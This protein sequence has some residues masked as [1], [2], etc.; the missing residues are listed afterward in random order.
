MSAGISDAEFESLQ[1]QAKSDLERVIPFADAAMQGADSE[2]KDDMWSSEKRKCYML[3]LVLLC[4]FE[5]VCE[6]LRDCSQSI[7]EGA[8]DIAGATSESGTDIGAGVVMAVEQ[9]LKTLA[10]ENTHNG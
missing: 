6:A 3:C 1:A 2:G 7:R 8:T 5:R 9:I 10:N 4:G